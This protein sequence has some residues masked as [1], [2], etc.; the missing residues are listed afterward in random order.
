MFSGSFVG[1]FLVLTWVLISFSGFS[2]LGIL[3]LLENFNI[4]ILFL[5]ITWG[6]LDSYINFLI[7][8]VVAT[9]EVTLGLVILTRLWNS[10]SFQI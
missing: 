6:S 1:L 8:M 9:I 3:L 5:V 7:F 4:F 10:D 2:Y